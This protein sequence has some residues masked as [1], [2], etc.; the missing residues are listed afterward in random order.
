MFLEIKN[1]S[2]KIENKKV[3]NNLNLK[4][5]VGEIHAIMGPNGCGKSTLAN[6]LAG[7]EDYEILSGEV[8]F[9]DKDLL[10]LNVEERAQEGMFLA[11][12]YPIEI[13]GVNITPFLHSAINSKNKKLNQEEIDNLSFAKL[14]KSKANEL[15]IN[16]DMLKRSVNTGFSG[17]EKKRYEI[18]QMSILN[19]DLAILD[20]TD[21]GLDI[22]AL[23]IVTKGVNKIKSKSNSFLIITHYQK[24]LDY[25]KPDFVHVMR[26][27]TIIKSGGTEIASEIEK[28]GF[29][30]FE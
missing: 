11:F 23:K 28:D 19:P 27:G 2:V 24:L 7:K 18:L 3:L 10:D 6:V 22:D 14:L 16:V 4:I 1:L 17:G 29:T 9:K 21:S 12:Q 25:I 30:V 13:P 20:E 5:N 8:T 15:G 26:N